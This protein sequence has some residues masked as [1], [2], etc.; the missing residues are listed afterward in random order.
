MDE[1]NKALRMDVANEI[2]RSLVGGDGVDHRGDFAWLKHP[3]VLDSRLFG[4]IM[5][6]F[7]FFNDKM[8]REMK[9]D[10]LSNLKDSCYMYRPNMTP[11][12]YSFDIYKDLTLEQAIKSFYVSYDN[13]S[14]VA[15]DAATRMRYAGIEPSVFNELNESFEKA[16][17]REKANL[18]VVSGE[19][20]GY[21]Y[22]TI[23]FW[24][25]ILL[26]VDAENN[27]A[28]I[29]VSIKKDLMEN[30]N[31]RL[32]AIT[33]SESKKP[34]YAIAELHENKSVG[35]K[36][37]GHNHPFEIAEV[38]REIQK[39]FAE[40]LNTRKEF[41]EPVIQISKNEEQGG[42]EYFQRRYKVRAERICERAFANDETEIPIRLSNITLG[43]DYVIDTYLQSN[44]E[45]DILLLA[46]ANE[47]TNN[48]IGSLELSDS[49]QSIIN[50]H[51]GKLCINL[52]EAS[53]YTMAK[54]AADGKI[55]V[56]KDDFC[57]LSE[58]YHPMSGNNARATDSFIVD[59]KQNVN[60]FRAGEEGGRAKYYSYSDRL[61]PK[62]EVRYQH[63]MEFTA[64][65]SQLTLEQEI[66]RSIQKGVYGRIVKYLDAQ[67]EKEKSETF[68]VGQKDIDFFK[69]IVTEGELFCEFDAITQNYSKNMKDFFLARMGGRNPPFHKQLESRIG[70]P[71]SAEVVYKEK[72]ARKSAVGEFWLRQNPLE[73]QELL[74][75]MEMSKNKICESS[76]RQTM[77]SPSRYDSIGSPDVGKVTHAITNQMQERGQMQR[78]GQ[79]I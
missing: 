70:Q 22:D 30:P 15:L 26:D 62:N 56:Q 44:G 36:I 3:S 74:S 11:D 46:R 65:S 16:L 25:S 9:R 47:N 33:N 66:F 41:T 8:P 51:D 24:D 55:L 43:R 20:L 60:Y 54:L 23:R 64:V 78:G 19:K 67:R 45:L 79:K 42:A 12:D 76:I 10:I 72:L 77:R 28:N 58:S 50:S 6:N 63:F 5:E 13:V 57:K 37:L 34:I 31:K 40:A 48:R 27:F 7:D 71:Y 32:V 38:I 18:P 29:S 59:G 39:N 53:F 2:I 4:S 73:I 49:L 21:K 17:L 1:T 61:A 35:V 52:H 69:A 14:T 75:T 68:V